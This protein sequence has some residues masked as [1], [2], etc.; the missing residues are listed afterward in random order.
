MNCPH[1]PPFFE[2]GLKWISVACNQKRTSTQIGQC[3][4]EQTWRKYVTDSWG[5]ELLSIFPFQNEKLYVF[6]S[7]NLIFLLESDIVLFGD[8]SVRILW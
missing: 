3:V 5:L 7:N 6:G 8:K 2:G 4:T 1:F